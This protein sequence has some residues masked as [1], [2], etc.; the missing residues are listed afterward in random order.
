MT[1]VLQLLLEC[2]DPINNWILKT[3]TGLKDSHKVEKYQTF[4][5]D[6]NLTESNNSLEATALDHGFIPENDGIAAVDLEKRLM[7]SLP[8]I[9]YMVS[10]PRPTDQ[11]TSMLSRCDAAPRTY[12]LQD[13]QDGFCGFT[14]VYEYGTREEVKRMYS[15]AYVI[16]VR[17]KSESACLCFS[18]M[19]KAPTKKPWHRDPGGKGPSRSVVLDLQDTSECFMRSTV[20]SKFLE[21][22]QPVE[23]NVQ[24]QCLPVSKSEYPRWMY[25]KIFKVSSFRNFDEVPIWCRNL[26]LSHITCVLRTLPVQDS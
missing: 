5:K 18:F 20:E 17:T 11:A 22:I 8:H 23:D 7:S 9:A 12:W 3:E 10:T 15:V 4:L 16:K 1:P 19:S 24:A 14:K 13:W 6:V 25:Q 26:S 2:R 21:L